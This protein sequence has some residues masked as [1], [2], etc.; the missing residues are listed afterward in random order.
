MGRNS[1]YGA[2]SGIAIAACPTTTSGSASTSVH[3]AS[4]ACIVLQEERR[5]D[6]G[7]CT[8]SS[9]GKFKTTNHFVSGGSPHSF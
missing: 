9:K 1:W 2:S 7:V 3:S 8:S 6:D 4:Y 5:E